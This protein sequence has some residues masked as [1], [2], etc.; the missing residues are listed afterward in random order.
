MSLRFCLKSLDGFGLLVR[1]LS[2]V[3]TPAVLVSVPFFSDFRPVSSGEPPGGG[4]TSGMV[5]GGGSLWRYG[6]VADLSSS[7]DGLLSGA[8]TA[9][10]PTGAVGI[11]VK[12]GG[13]IFVLVLLMGALGT[14]KCDFR[15]GGGVGGRI[16]RELMTGSQ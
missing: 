7:E 5:S 12:M 1:G 16:H 15:G 10:G 3:V 2:R 4:T 6:D 8:G 14:V 9:D 13:T 11:F